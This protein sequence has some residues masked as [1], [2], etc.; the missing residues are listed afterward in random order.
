M[1]NRAKV[2]HI[3]PTI[4]RY[5]ALVGVRQVVVQFQGS[6]ACCPYCGAPHPWPAEVPPQMSVADAAQEILAQFEQGWPRQ[7][8]FAGG[9]PL[10]Y[11]DWIR[12]LLAELPPCQ[13][14]V[15]T[16]GAPVRE[17]A[18]L[19]P[20]ATTFSLHWQVVKMETLLA[21]QQD[22]EYALQ[23]LALRQSGEL[24]LHL[25]EALLRD[26]TLLAL[27][28]R[29]LQALLAGAASLPIWLALSPASVTHTAEDLR[30]VD[31]CLAVFPQARV[32]RALLEAPPCPWA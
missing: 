14:Q 1:G 25:S 32:I 7:L 31:A 12:R 22:V 24:V 17:L 23:L 18:A 13:V 29:E 6:E 8:A 2:K 3:F 19:L 9:E 27:R 5:G 15:K 28:V 4:E 26:Q 11:A 30:S 21:A 16:K 20:F 10:I